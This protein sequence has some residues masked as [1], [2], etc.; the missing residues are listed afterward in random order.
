MWDNPQILIGEEWLSTGKVHLIQDPYTGNEVARVPLGDADL[1]RRAVH[2]ARDA[3]ALTRKQ[4]P[5]ERASLLQAVAAGIELRR[6][7]FV[8]CLIAEAGKPRTFAEAEVTRAV[9][10]FQAAAEASRAPMAESLAID[11]YAVGKDHLGMARRFPMGVIAAI[12]P[13]NFPLNLVA[14]KVA[15]C[16]A[17]GNTMV[18]KPAMKTPLCSLLLGKVLLK[19]GMTPGQVNIVTCSNEDASVLLDHPD[20]RM[21]SFTG[22]PD[23]GWN[24]KSRAQKKKVCLELGGNAAVVVHEDADLSVA[25]PAIATGAFA[26]AGQSCISVQRILVHRPIYEAFKTQFLKHV[27]AHIHTGDPRESATVVGPMINAEARDRVRSW[28][29]AAVQA[30]GRLLTG[31]DCAGPCLRPTVL[32]GVPRDQAISAQEAFAPVVVLDVYDTFREALDIVNDS[33]FG[34]QAGIYTRD[35][36]RALDAW[37][38]LEVGGVL[39]NNVPTFRVETMPYG[40]V[41]DSGFGREGVR[42]TME[43]MTELKSLIVRTHP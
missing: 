33:T 31:G 15:P 34:L 2:T 4:A 23:V 42:Y 27:A 36:Q 22:S 11:G 13:F 9:A 37:N 40:G 20:I 28:I 10:T 14:H 26:Y 30:G 19:A 41:K 1:L 6:A 5:F 35:L 8:D 25:I 21:V 43:E 12:T 3:F 24:L 29:D 39:V 32:E 7:D 16:L 38:E 17:T 18:L